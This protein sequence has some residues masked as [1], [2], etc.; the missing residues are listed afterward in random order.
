MTNRP[1]R[2]WSAFTPSARVEMMKSATAGKRNAVSAPEQE[3]RND[4]AAE[5]NHPKVVPKELSAANK[6]TPAEA[7]QELAWDAMDA[8]NEEEAAGLAR[9]ALALDP[10]CVDA[11]LI[12]SDIDAHSTKEAI[13]AVEKAVE[14]GERTLGKEY[15]AKNTGYFW[16]LV[17]TRPYM[18]ALLQ[19]AVLRQSAGHLRIAIRLYDKML[20]LNPTDNQGVRELA[21]GCYLAANDLDGAQALLQRYKIDE[22]ATFLWGRVLERFLSDNRSGARRALKRAREANGYVELYM[23]GLRPL[24]SEVPETY[25]LGSESEALCVLENLMQ[26][27]AKHQKA[28]FWLIDH[29]NPLGIPKLPRASRK[30]KEIVQ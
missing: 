27:W 10:D 7:A 12:L 20:N 4:Q 17:E 11:L 25:T 24:P 13:A 5:E 3:K 18:R 1:R 9:S 2:C 15:I 22:S 19:L 6:L 8:E 26:A 23:S 28:I 14:A 16:G 21:L 30:E 29:L